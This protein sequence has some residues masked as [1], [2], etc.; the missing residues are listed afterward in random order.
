MQVNVAKVSSRG[1]VVIPREIREELGLREG[2][3]LLVFRI[4]DSIVL[5]S[6]S[7]TPSA[8]LASNLE[9]IRKKIKELGITRTDVKAEIGTVRMSRKKA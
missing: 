8:E 7:V 2:N 5:K 6:P 3:G 1:Q 9:A 4:G